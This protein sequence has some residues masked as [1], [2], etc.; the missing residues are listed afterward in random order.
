MLLNLYARMQTAWFG[1]T[2]RIRDERGAVATEYALLL[3]FIAVAIV[4]TVTAL[5]L[6][7]KAKFTSACNGLGGSGC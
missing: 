5:G 4:T 3:F 7:V 2:G 6:A 1:M